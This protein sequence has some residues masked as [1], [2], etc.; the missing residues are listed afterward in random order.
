[1]TQK[2][3]AT[4][5]DVAQRAGVSTAVVS[6]VINGGPRP[7]SAEMRNRVLRAID[8]LDYHPNSAA[9]GL[10]RRR[11]N[12]VAFVTYDFLPAESFSSHYLG[13]MLTALTRELQIH[14]HYLLMF[15]LAIG[16]D[17]M[18]LR[19]MLKSGRVDSLVIRFVQDSPHSDDLLKIV[20]ECAIPCVCLERPGAGRF[21]FPAVTYDDGEGARLAT[22]HLIQLGHERIAHLCG[23][24]RYA[25]AQARLASYRQALIDVGIAVD[26]RLIAEAEWNTRLAIRETHRLLDLPDP[27]TA[28]FAA[29]DDMAFGALHAARDRGLRVPDDL[30]VVGFDD[31]PL[32]DELTPLLTTIRAPLDDMGIRAAQLLTE[33]ASPDR[34]PQTE[35]RPVVLVQRAST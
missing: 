11:T 15:P 31:I 34:V 13:R 3:R 9:R 7:T 12:T 1:M 32:A 26:N 4:L 35:I 10:R 14:G 6:Y 22:N 25:T 2:K 29:S 18:P 33:G 5:R 30:A 20:H 27:P 21:G 17:P 28:I 8:E 16:D 19:R 24:M 23:D